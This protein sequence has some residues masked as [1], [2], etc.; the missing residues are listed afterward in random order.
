MPPECPCCV[1]E[2]AGAAPR[3]AIMRLMKTPFNRTRCAQ[4]NRGLQRGDK[5]EISCA[6]IPVSSFR[7]PRACPGGPIG[8]SIVTPEFAE[9]YWM[10]GTSP[11]MT[12]SVGVI[13]KKIAETGIRRFSGRRGR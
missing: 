13:V 11:A 5:P 9:S 4:C 6:A 2:P 8:R 3:P 12:K 7:H 10:A 1:H